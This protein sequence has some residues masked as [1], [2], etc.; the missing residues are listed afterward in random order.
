MVI[1]LTVTLEYGTQTGCAMI[2]I[3]IK[4]HLLLA[5][6]KRANNAS[7]AKALSRRLNLLMRCKFYYL[8]AEA[9]ARLERFGKLNRK[10]EVD[11]FEAFDNQIDFGE[12]SNA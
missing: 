3:M 10:R 12:I 9:K 2:C 8:F 11:D 7:I 5:I 6:S 4:P 1:M